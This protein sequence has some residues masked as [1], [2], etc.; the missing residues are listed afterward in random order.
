ML[1]LRP[2]S[3]YELTRQM[4]RSLSY[5][6]PTVESV[7]YHEPKRLVRLGLADAQS[8]PVGTR[9]RTVYSITGQGRQVLTQWLAT[10]PAPPRLEVPV[11]LRLLYADQAGKEDLLSTVKAARQWALGRAPEV[12]AQV[13]GYLT[14]GGPFPERLHIIALFARFYVDLFEAMIQWCDFAEDQIQTWP[15]TANLGMNDRTRTLLEELEGRLQAFTDRAAKDSGQ[16]SDRT[17]AHEH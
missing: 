2:W 14:D 17:S 4:R 7:L 3:A 12:L 8:Q 1:A 13:R 5:C 6:L 16:D 11:M 9:S 10:P 15:H